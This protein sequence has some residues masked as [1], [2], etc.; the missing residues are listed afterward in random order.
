V[1]E[2]ISLATKSGLKYYEAESRLALAHIQYDLGQIQ[3]SLDLTGE[4]SAKILE[5]NYTD[6]VFAL[7]TLQ[8]KCYIFL[9]SKSSAQIRSLLQKALRIAQDHPNAIYKAELSKISKMLRI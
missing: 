1:F 3:E 8:A 9:H 4:I 7:F 5:Q 2:S 6:N